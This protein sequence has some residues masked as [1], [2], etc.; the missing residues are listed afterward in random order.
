M[1]IK[2]FKGV[3]FD[4]DGVITQTAKI[5][6]K[7]WKSMFNEFLKK[8]D[9]PGFT[10]FDIGEDYKQYIDGKPRLDGVKSFLDSRNIILEEGNTSDLSADSIVGLG[11]KKNARFLELLKDEGVEVYPDTI[12]L[13]KLWKN[14]MR[15][16]VVTASKNCQFIMESAG[17]LDFF[18][19]RVDGVYA[20]EKNLPGKPAPDIFL[21]ASKL[22]GLNPSQCILFEDARAG[23]EAGKRGN[24]GLVIGVARDGSPGGLLNSGADFVVENLDQVEQKINSH[25]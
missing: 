5:H 12:R 6:A 24:F 25:V 14:K 9:G 1:D 17:I 4:M 2:N 10:P 13:V 15:L 21:E 18:D 22:M 7:A 20:A 3:I 16:A 19:V 8:L 11:E 23:V